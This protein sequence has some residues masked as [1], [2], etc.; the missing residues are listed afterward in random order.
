[1][2]ENSRSEEEKPGA[3]ASLAEICSGIDDD[4][5]IIAG[6]NLFTSS[7]KPMIQTFESRRSPVVALY[8]VKKRELVKQYSAATIDSEGR[9]IRLVEKPADPET[10][11]IGTCI[12]A[13]PT[14]TLA[15]LR[16]YVVQETDRDAPGR[17]IEWL[18]KRETIYGYLLNGFWW[19]IGTVD[20]YLTANQTLTRLVGQ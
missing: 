10:T 1:M 7:L 13:L 2:A 16:E 3:V 11:L 15:R 18:H 6:D 20:Q 9:I 19:D 14:R 12:Y 4:C 17:F 5:L 8:D